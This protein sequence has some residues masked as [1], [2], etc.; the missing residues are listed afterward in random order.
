MGR[1]GWKPAVLHS[2]LKA[3]REHVDDLAHARRGL[4]LGEATSPYLDSA[5]GQRAERVPAKRRLEV[6]RDDPASS[7][8]RCCAPVGAAI[9]PRVEPLPHEHARLR[10]VDVGTATLVDLHAREEQLGFALGLET[11][12]LGLSVVGLSELRSVA[13][14]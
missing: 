3:A 13:L 14:A 7:L 6:T 8:S 12:L 2:H 5:V 9:H 10:R 1:V 4:R 11:A